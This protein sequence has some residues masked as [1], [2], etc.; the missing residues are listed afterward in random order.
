MIM[1]R[2]R[3]GQITADYFDKRVHDFLC[4]QFDTRTDS[5]D[6]NVKQIKGVKIFMEQGLTVLD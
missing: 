2:H 3:L 6:L 1:L 5:F 4:T